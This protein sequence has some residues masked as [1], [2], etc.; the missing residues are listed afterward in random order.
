MLQ[1]SGCRPFAPASTSTQ[2]MELKNKNQCDC[3]KLYHGFGDLEKQNQEIAT[4]T[5][6]Y[7][8]FNMTTLHIYMVLRKSCLAGYGHLINFHTK[9]E[10][11][12]QG[13]I[14]KLQIPD[15]DPLR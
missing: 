8:L 11:S 1:T 9:S 13:F 15:R 6:R 5:V 4:Y 10:D 3:E 7:V 12:F 14:Q 2:V